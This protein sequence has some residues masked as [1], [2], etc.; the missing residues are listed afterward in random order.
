[1]RRRVGSP[2]LA[3]HVEVGRRV[4]GDIRTILEH[5][6]RPLRP[7]DRVLDWGCGAGRVALQLLQ[8]DRL[9]VRGCDVDHEAIDWLRGAIPDGEQRFQVSGFAPP[10]PYPD[11]SFEIVYA[12]SVFTHLDQ[13]DQLV[14]LRELARVLA[15]G[16]TALLTTAGRHSFERP[17]WGGMPPHTAKQLVPKLG[18]LE[19]L[20]F[21]FVSYGDQLVSRREKYPGISGDY[22][23]AFQSENW[24]RERWGEVLEIEQVLPAAVGGYQDAVVVTVP[25]T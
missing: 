5:A 18:R 14:W 15:P 21:V 3:A 20:G 13:G 12:V 8:S 24:T 7:G 2:T 17:F 10:L 4:A 1:M 19:E 9:D 16:G 25:Q 22:G 11:H 23:L 6:G